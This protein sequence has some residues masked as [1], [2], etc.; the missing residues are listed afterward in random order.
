MYSTYIYIH[1]LVII[2]TLKV[3]II[4]LKV[5]IISLKGLNWLLIQFIHHKLHFGLRCSIRHLIFELVV[6]YVKGLRI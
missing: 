3:I 2:I 4:S 6:N 1:K 5:I